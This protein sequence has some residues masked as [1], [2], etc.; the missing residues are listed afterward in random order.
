[1]SQREEGAPPASGW[2]PLAIELHVDDLNASTAFWCGLLLFSVA[3]QRLEERFACLD[4]NGAQVML[5][6]RHGRWETGPMERPFAR[7]AM[8]QVATNDLDGV[9]R[10]L[11]HAGWPIHTGP[12]EIWRRVGD[13]EA[14]LRELFVQDPDGYLVMMN[15]S[16]GER[17]IR[18]A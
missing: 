6:Q 15:Q 17:P 2:A 16:I 12:H 10:R 13:R 1:M 18:S 4:L 7:G 3:F 11:D 8:L 9:E 5:C 14:G